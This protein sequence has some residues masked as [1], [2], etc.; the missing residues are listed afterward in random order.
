MVE[1]QALQAVQARLTE[2]G[3]QLPE[4]PPPAG[5]YLP[6]I[7][8]GQLVFTSGQLPTIDGRLPETGKVGG[9]VSP[10]DAKTYARTC[11]LNGLAA[12]A[13]A[14]GSLDRVTRVVRIAGFVASEP[15]FT[16]QPGVVDGA[17]ELLIEIFGEAGRHV[18]TAVGVAALPLDSPVEVE[19]VLE[20]K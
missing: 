17:S 10:G 15:T 6:A 19:L 9:S 11:V 2:L 3:L 5:S 1:V 16:G 18:R 13:S 14:I 20:F 8:T 4:V 12:A 7:A